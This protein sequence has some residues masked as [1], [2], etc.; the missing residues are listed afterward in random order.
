MSIVNVFIA[1]NIPI[2]IPVINTVNSI[3]NTI[4]LTI[5]NDTTD[6]STDKKPA[7][8]NSSTSIDVKKTITINDNYNP[9]KITSIEIDSA[10]IYIEKG[11]KKA[12]GINLWA[13][14]GA[15]DEDEEKDVQ[16]YIYKSMAMAVDATTSVGRDIADTIIKYNPGTLLYNGFAN[17]AKVLQKKESVKENSNA[18]KKSNAN[19]QIKS[20][21]DED[22]D[23]NI[24]NDDFDFNQTW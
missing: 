21:N 16:D 8:S 14:L 24:D 23:D 15:A 7:I 3:I 18:N 1:P 12:H 9:I 2:V 17:I 11:K 4:Y 5:Y 13:A 20:D 22:D 19:T 10:N 6:S